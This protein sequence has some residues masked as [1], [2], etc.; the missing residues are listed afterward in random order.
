MEGNAHSRVTLAR[1]LELGLTALTLIAAAV[2]V[3][4]AVKSVLRSSDPGRA[5][6]GAIVPLGTVDWSAHNPTLLIA[7][8][9]GC[10]FCEASMP[11]YRELLA[12]NA[13]GNFRPILVFPQAGAVAHDFLKSHK[14]DIAE[15]RQVD[16]NGLQIDGT[17]T[18]MLVGGDGRLIA[19]WIGKLSTTKEQDVFQR[20]RL[21]R[22]GTVSLEDEKPAHNPWPVVSAA[23][24]S[25]IYRK[26]PIVDTRPRFNFRNGHIAGSLNIPLDELGARLVHEVPN[27]I[28]MAVFCNYCARCE[29]GGP[30][31]GRQSYCD[32]AVESMKELGF[33]K[34]Q[35]VDADLSLLRSAGID[36]AYGPGQQ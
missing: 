21:K 17:P 22:V 8:Q 23:N 34:V 19:S 33:S 2:F 1:M 35:V 15:V 24:I 6:I 10:R 18:L 14:L 5:A 3:G 20:L 12:S 7:L 31:S 28:E 25:K 36:V 26:I 29:A 13:A 27:D 9:Q 16:F 4:F 30:S 11:F 32:S